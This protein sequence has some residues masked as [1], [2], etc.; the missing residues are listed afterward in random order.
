MMS[1]DDAI[2]GETDGC[3]PTV[4]SVLFASSIYVAVWFS[5]E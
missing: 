4:K 2:S 3:L 1:V 5:S